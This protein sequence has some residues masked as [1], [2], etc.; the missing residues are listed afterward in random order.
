MSICSMIPLVCSRLLK[1]LQ[2]GSTSTVV[3]P[4]LASFYNSL[5]HQSMH[6]HMSKIFCHNLLLD[7]TRATSQQGDVHLPSSDFQ[8][9]G[10]VTRETQELV[11]YI[12]TY[13]NLEGAYSVLESVHVYRGLSCRQVFAN[14]FKQLNSETASHRCIS[15]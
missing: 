1:S 10:Y 9:V 12:K 2:D 3:Y 7:S 15:H 14:V 11:M 4:L 8:V 6:F 13:R 5:K